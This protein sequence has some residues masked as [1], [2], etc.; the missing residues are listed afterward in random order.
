MPQRRTLAP[1]GLPARVVLSLL[2]T[3]GFFYVN[4]MPAIVQGL[5]D[6]LAFTQRQA[7]LVG[8]FNMYGAA[9]GAMLA[10][11]LLVRRVPW[12][13]AAVLMLGALIALDLV[14][15]LLESPLPFI[16]VRFAHGMAGG[17]LIGFIYAVMARTHEPDRSFG[18]LLFVQFGLGGL[19]VLFLPG[20]VPQF[21]TPVLFGAL[22]AVSATALVLLPLLDAYPAPLPPASS[23]TAGGGINGIAAPPRPLLMTLGA[24]F[25]FQAGNMALFAYVIGLGEA[26]ELGRDFVT[27][28]LFAGAWIGL[29]GSAL[30]VWLST[31]H[32]RLRPLLIAIVLTVLGNAALLWSRVPELFVFANLLVGMT[33]AFVMPY[34]LGMCAAF[35]PHGRMA[36]LG[37]LASKLGL[38]T[39]PLVAAL[40]I[41]DA[42]YARVILLSL[43]ALCVCCAL[44]VAPAVRL[45]RSA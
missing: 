42:Q 41:G 23:P 26:A 7:G 31:R 14:S 9:A 10:V 43:L 4:I 21:G 29:G 37:G 44:V 30:V 13:P 40:L 2:A 1:D 33:W 19:G 12:R 32:G 35:D 15:M 6:A 8:S 39:G 17:T 36:A 11:L 25:L 34:L 45:D 24:I 28:T 27:G 20:L 5:I 38:A 3:A 22:I 18:V 16:A